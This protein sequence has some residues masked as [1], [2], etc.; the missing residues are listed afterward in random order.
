M[1]RK[2][3]RSLAAAKEPV[4]LPVLRCPVV[5]EINLFL[6]WNSWFWLFAQFLAAE[7]LD[8]DLVCLPVE[9]FDDRHTLDHYWSRVAG[10]KISLRNF[11][12]KQRL[13]IH[14]GRVSSV[15]LRL[16]WDLATPR[17]SSRGYRGSISVTR[18]SSLEVILTPLRNQWRTGG[19]LEGP[20]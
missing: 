13:L 8:L 9:L 15:S 5:I 1:I 19:G 20:D 16:S 2:C 11:E 17:L 12:Y 7:Y 6:M 4:F 14:L 10:K 3:F 18:F